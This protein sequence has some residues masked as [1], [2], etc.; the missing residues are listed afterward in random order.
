MSRPRVGA[1]S[2][3]GAAPGMV[4]ANTW[5]KTSFV[6]G[7][8]RW[9]AQDAPGSG[10]TRKWLIFPYME[11]TGCSWIRLESAWPGMF[12]EGANAIGLMNNFF[13]R[14]NIPLSPRSDSLQPIESKIYQWSRRCLPK[15][16]SS[17][18]YMLWNI[19]CETLRYRYSANTDD[20]RGDV[21][22]QKD[23]QRCKFPKSIVS[24][25]W[26][27]LD[28]DKWESHQRWLDWPA[29][30][31]P[32]SIIGAVPDASPSFEARISWLHRECA[33]F[34]HLRMCWIFLHP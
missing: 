9:G 16:G 26:F 23:L 18:T 24:V 33:I 30:H 7:R 3:R 29:L 2:G 19:S 17:H 34:A 21:H 12:L 8:H 4:R 1:R 27:C 5:W 20:A 6:G 14:S 22:Y 10:T 15:S 25:A 32:F 11:G 13:D 28:D 31:T